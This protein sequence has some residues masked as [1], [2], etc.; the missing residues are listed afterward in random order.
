[1]IHE[2]RRNAKYVLTSTT[3]A[4]KKE[5]EERRSEENGSKG[6]REG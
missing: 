1:M 5:S 4:L 3:Q 2:K 6:R